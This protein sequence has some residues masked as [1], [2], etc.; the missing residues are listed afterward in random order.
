M[1]GCYKTIIKARFST[2][3]V[4]S[5]KFSDLLQAGLTRDRNRAIETAQI[6][7]DH[8]APP[9]GSGLMDAILGFIEQALQSYFVE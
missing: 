4:Q 7:E 9:A 2:N 6:I 1:S 5:A 8:A 3:V